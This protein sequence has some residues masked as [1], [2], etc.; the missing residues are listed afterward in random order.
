MRQLLR[1]R[2]DFA[3]GNQN[4]HLDQTDR[5]NWRIKTRMTPFKIVENRIDGWCS[6]IIS[7][8]L[9]PR[10]KPLV[11][12][13]DIS[14]H[15]SVIRSEIGQK[16]AEWI[17]QEAD[18]Q[19]TWEKAAYYHS[20][21]GIG[22]F[23]VDVKFNPYALYTVWN[24][25][26]RVTFRSPG[27]DPVI[28]AVLPQRMVVDPHYEN[29]EDADCFFNVEPYTIGEAAAL[30]GKSEK[31]V[32]ANVETISNDNDIWNNIRQTSQDVGWNVWR[33]PNIQWEIEN[34]TLNSLLD[35]D[36]VLL[37]EYFEKYD[38]SRWVRYILLCMKPKSDSGSNT[39]VERLV[40]VAD[41]P[42][43][44]YTGHVWT[45][46]TT[47]LYPT[48]PVTKVIERQKQFNA[49]VNE[50]WLRVAKNP[51]SFVELP[52]GV[53]I[54]SE[55]QHGERIKVPPGTQVNM[56][57]G[58][59]IPPDIW[60]I[61]SWIEKNISEG[62]GLTPATKGQ[63]PDKVY[64]ATA[65]IDVGEGEAHRINQAKHLFVQ[66]YETTIYKAL[67]M[68]N[69]VWTPERSFALIGE[70]GRSSE[71]YTWFEGGVDDMQVHVDSTF[72]NETTQQARWITTF[73]LLQKGYFGDPQSYMARQAA[74][75]AMGG[76]IFKLV[77]PEEKQARSTAR[78]II[79]AIREW[80]MGL[81][82]MAPDQ[83]IQFIFPKYGQ[84]SE[85][86]LADLVAFTSS[87][88]FLHMQQTTQ[89]I[90]AAV[91]MAHQ[92]LIDAQMAEAQQ[93]IEQGSVSNAGN[94][95]SGDV[96]AGE[97]IDSAGTPVVEI[98][99]RGPYGGTPA[100]AGTGADGA[101]I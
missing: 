66:A 17:S 71:V 80:E 44:P 9:N 39:V 29:I 64:S 4:L 7:L 10:R 86:I 31:W 32:K 19:G 61:M 22:F 94:N 50:L 23:K 24:G 101:P 99:N 48:S 15:D 45:K 84:N 14:S 8:L 37:K 87:P 62:L 82:R 18:R 95:G 63:F 56:K 70:D 35:D 1:Y 76:D 93:A 81:S 69:M 65:T 13:M 58:L 6:S 47:G 12:P 38:E 30:L 43:C 51:K 33:D 20:T 96:T 60:N 46:R 68:A 27:Y 40:R 92:S 73:Q 26:R 100:Y 36:K 53:E 77:R 83:F 88:E 90:L 54:S 91:I 67:Q 2:F 59:V 75:L 21:P 74:E 11:T 5:H 57:D 34:E 49:I 52:M 85:V 41:F 42:F 72:E 3:E 28:R 89:E 97:P 25:N 78:A 79:R 98:D 55:G 16:F